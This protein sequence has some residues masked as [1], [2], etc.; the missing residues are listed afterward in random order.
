MALFPPKA[1]A[2]GWGKVA[3]IVEWVGLST[4]AFQAFQEITGNLG[5]PIRNIAMLSPTV[6]ADA[7]RRAR[8]AE[9]PLE[10]VQVA[11][12]GLI[13]RIARRIAVSLGGGATAWEDW[14]D[15]D[16]FEPKK[17]AAAAAPAAPAGSSKENVV[18]L[19]KV[20]DQRDESEIALASS[21]THQKWVEAY[22]AAT[23]GEDP[24]PEDT[25]SIQQLTALHHRVYAMRSTPY[26]DFGV[27]GPFGRKAYRNMQFRAWFLLPGGG[28]LA[29]EL[30]GPA[31]YDQW[32]MS[33]RVFATA[34][35]MLEIASRAALDAYQ[36][37]I[38]RLAT[39]WP[40]A[41]LLIHMADDK[42][43][44][45]FIER[46]RRTVVKNMSLGKGA[47]SDWNAD[48]P[49][50]ALFLYAV[51]N[52]EYWN[53]QVRDPAA[54]W[55]ARGGKG[56][57][58]DP[59][60]QVAIRSLP[61][62]ADVVRKKPGWGRYAPVN[63]KE[64]EREWSP[65][66]PRERCRRR[67]RSRSRRARS[68]ARAA[69]TEK[70]MQVCYSFSKKIG[71]CKGAA[72][73]S[74][75]PAGRRHVCHVCGSPNHAGHEK[76]CQGTSAKGK[77][78]GKTG[79]SA[80]ELTAPRKLARELEN[81]TF[82]GG[83]RNPA[84]AVGLNPG[85]ARAGAVARRAF[86]DFV[87]DV[88]EERVS[89]HDLGAPSPL[90]GA[91]I[92]G[93][94]RAA[95]DP[96]SQ[97]QE[98]IEQ[99]VPLGTERPIVPCGVFPPVEPATEFKHLLSLEEAV[100][101]GMGN[102]ASLDD[103]PEDAKIEL[104]RLEANGFYITV[105]EATALEW[106]PDGSVAK[107]ALIVTLK[108]NGTVKRRIIIDMLRGVVG[109]L[110]TADMKDAYQHFRVREAELKHCLTRHWR[111]S[112]IMIWVMM[113]FGLK[114]APLVWGRFAAAVARLLQGLYRP[115]EA[116]LE[117]Y[118][119]DPLWVLYGTPRQRDFLLAMSLWML[120][121]FGL[122][123]SWSKG[124]RGALVEWIGVSIDVSYAL[125]GHVVRPTVLGKFL[126]DV[127]A[128]SDAILGTSMAGLRRLRRLTG[129]LS[130][131]A[132]ALP[133]TR[134]AVN[135]LWA[136]VASA[137]R[138]AAKAAQG[139]GHRRAGHR[140][141]FLVATSRCR[142]ALTWL[143][144]VWRGVQS[145]P[146]VREVSLWPGAP[147]FVVVTDASPWGLGAI[148]YDRHAQGT[149]EYIASPLN[150]WDTRLLGIAIGECTSQAVAELLA[151]VVAVRAWGRYFKT[152]IY[153]VLNYLAA[154]LA[155][156]LETHCLPDLVA[157]HV[158]GSRNVVADWLSRLQAPQG[159]QG[160]NSADAIAHAKL[161]KVVDRDSGYYALPDPIKFTD[162]WGDCFGS[163][164][165]STSWSAVGLREG[166]PFVCQ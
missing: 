159:Q 66:I 63:N 76:K 53:E 150:H 106:F 3:D 154:E 30:P 36:R 59:D 47:P 114:S 28:W 42:L 100:A 99:G 122:T 73:G 107:L 157:Q 141:E 4:N 138:D 158:A 5:D 84:R 129:K 62:G 54:A 165:G 32:L 132:G 110:A 127:V 1:T 69:P 68:E 35:I 137:I 91:F 92:Q 128:E 130:W 81:T 67:S 139:Q 125:V 118:L 116:R 145:G 105:D 18:K 101:S 97:L 79:K 136:I 72:P 23:S 7:G 64:L 108:A 61:G 56:V 88:P 70:K 98:W 22:A 147:R 24:V 131:A 140:K 2:L 77:G 40:D 20:L 9:T 71:P 78:D 37:H 65:S 34:C 163:N 155:L 17:E 14:V 29:K 102:Y 120:S 27:W 57:P 46:F 115:G 31:N 156:F 51:A 104:D 74:K 89:A 85:L 21:S 160:D 123:M 44:A 25:P 82:P 41:W 149:I 144:A 45:E 134:W 43:R 152:S 6:I 94:L 96:E 58:L 111:E 83:M 80:G 93:W 60:E 13:W 113:S 146:K 86:E 90:Q 16:P 153:H 49:W 48:K 15:L 161:R 148:L 109:G 26:A 151:V 142:L 112:L 19:S 39:Q 117:L 119:D 95:N 50:T 143:L 87:A 164:F 162:L 52:R 12:W 166:A 55:L 126:A 10:P 103:N 11:Q 135:I 8:L 124:S 75:C 33:W 133:R 121:A 38:E